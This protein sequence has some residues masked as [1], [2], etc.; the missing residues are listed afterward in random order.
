M[1][2]MTIIIPTTHLSYGTIQRLCCVIYHKNPKNSD[3]RRI[4]VIILKFE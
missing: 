2:D 4:A 1:H 3:T